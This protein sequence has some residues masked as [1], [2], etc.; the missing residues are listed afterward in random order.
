TA[1]KLRL[2]VS[3]ESTAGVCANASGLEWKSIAP[4]ATTAAS[5]VANRMNEAG[6]RQ[7]KIKHCNINLKAGG[8]SA[9]LVVV[10]PSCILV[11]KCSTACCTALASQQ[12]IHHPPRSLSC[13]G[14]DGDSVPLRGW[15]PNGK[16]EESFPASVP[17]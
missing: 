3:S 11:G 8:A 7:S 10:T 14:I 9:R 13:P 1:P 15:S 5:N 4:T 12:P 17:A 2:V 6:R 16:H